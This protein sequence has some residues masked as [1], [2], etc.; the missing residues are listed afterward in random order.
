MIIDFHYHYLDT[1]NTI[2]DLLKDMDEAGVDKT[3][4]IGGP[5][6]AFWGLNNLGLKDNGSVSASN[7]VL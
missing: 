5:D 3:L 6:N 1:E 4:I 7:G 2:A